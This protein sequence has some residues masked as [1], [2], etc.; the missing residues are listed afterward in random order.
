M[1]GQIATAAEQQSAVA[2]EMSQNL[3]NIDNLTRK[4]RVD[5]EQVASSSKYLTSLARNLQNAANQFKLG[6]WF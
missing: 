2:N 3:E 6:V 1:N 4:S 5:A